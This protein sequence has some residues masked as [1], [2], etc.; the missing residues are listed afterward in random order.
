MSKELFREKLKALRL[1]AQDRKSVTAMALRPRF[2]ANETAILTRQIEHVRAKTF[3]VQ[4]AECIARQFIPAATDI[5]S[6]AS[7]VVEVIYDSFGQARLGGSYSD[8]APRADIIASESSFKVYSLFSAYGWNLAELRAALGT[9]VPLNELKAGMARRMIE[10]ATD[11]ILAL[12][13]LSGV[14][15]DVGLKGISNLT[16]ATLLASTATGTS[17]VG[18]TAAEILKDLNALVRKSGSDTKQLYESDTLLVPVREHDI[19]TSTYYSTQNENTV[20]DVF[21]KNNP[22]IS[23]FKWN[24][25]DGAGASSANR[26]IAFKRS[27][28]VLEAVVPQEFEQLAPE[29]R[30]FETIVNCHSRVGGVRVHQPKAVVYMDL[31]SSQA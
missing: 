4:Y 31:D 24:R 1:K 27:P 7:H 30:N 19:M 3:S 11:E 26:L 10:V 28:E 17:W 29:Q 13:K 5:P 16:G 9:G 20:L 12:G 14:G 8:D 18:G 6:W 21:K 23:V 22:Q 2:D 15:Q 25:L